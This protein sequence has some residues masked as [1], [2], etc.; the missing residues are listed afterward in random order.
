MILRA[1]PGLPLNNAR[2][3]GEDPGHMPQ[4]EQLTRI[5]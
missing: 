3:G 5:G 2:T 4:G 1:G